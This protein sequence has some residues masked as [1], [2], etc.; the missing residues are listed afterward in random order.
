M[1]PT[2]ADGQAVT[3]HYRLTLDDGTIAEDSFA[4]D[5]IVYLHGQNQIV[6]GLERQLAGKA[7]GETHAFVVD[8]VDGYGELDPDG[9]RTVSRSELPGHVEIQVGMVLQGEGPNGVRLLWVDRIEGDQVTLTANHP[10]AGERLNFEVQILE[11]RAAS[12]EE[13]NPPDG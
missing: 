11:V 7:T 8:P 6:P 13:L 12:A 1:S 10:L 2:I 3:I 4:R 5:P 9:E